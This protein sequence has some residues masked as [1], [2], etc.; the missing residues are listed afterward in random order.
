MQRRARYLVVVLLIVLPIAGCG[1]SSAEPTANS[2]PV[3]VTEH[4]NGLNGELTVDGSTTMEPLVRMLADEFQTIHPG[5]VLDVKSSDSG[6][7]IEAVRSGAVDIGMSSR[8]LSDDEQREGITIHPIAIDM[9]AIIVHPTN[10][11]RDITSEQLHAIFVGQ[12]TNWQELGGP[13]M[14]ILPIIREERS[15]TRATFDAFVMDEQEYAAAAELQF[16]TN[17]VELDVASRAEAI[18]YVSAGHL[19]TDEVAVLAIDGSYPSQETALD[20]SYPIQRSLLLLTG[21]LSRDVSTLFIDFACSGE[22]QQLIQEDG[23]I[24]VQP[25]EA[26]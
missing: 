10:P 9:I 17:L 24:P 7:G 18:G 23:W 25:E 15:G 5:V 2:S 21:P 13:D 8:A 1:R 6:L 26:D 11:V 16:S 4:G 20:G 12:I 3:V 22:G 19:K 14:E